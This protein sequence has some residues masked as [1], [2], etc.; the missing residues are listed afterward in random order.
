MLVKAQKF[1]V[2]V[3]WWYSGLRVWHCHC[4]GSGHCCGAS[5]VFGLGTSACCWHGQEKKSKHTRTHCKGAPPNPQRKRPSPWGSDKQKAAPPEVHHSGKPEGKAH[6]G[7]PSPRKHLTIVKT[8]CPGVPFVAQWLMN[9]TRNHEDSSSIP[10]L[11]PWLK[12]LV[13]P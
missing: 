9:P 10:G 6:Q 12:D 5:S 13:L 4:C 8:D 11:A 2:G 1:T 7:Q 3:P